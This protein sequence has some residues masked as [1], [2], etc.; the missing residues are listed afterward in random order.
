MY[1]TDYCQYDTDGAK[2]LFS[3]KH[4][5]HLSVLE[6]AFRRQ[7]GGT[8][9]NDARSLIQ[10]QPIQIIWPVLAICL[11]MLSLNFIGDGLS[12]ALDPKKK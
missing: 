4:S 8:M 7:A 5:L 1:G 11:T 2:M 9:A 3:R 10:S 12:E 6:S